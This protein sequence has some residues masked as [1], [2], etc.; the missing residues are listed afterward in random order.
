MSFGEIVLGLLP[1]CIFTVSN[2]LVLATSL[3]ESFAHM[4]LE[5]HLWMF[6]SIGFLEKNPWLSLPFTCPSHECSIHCQ[7]EKINRKP[8]NLKKTVPPQCK[9]LWLDQF[10]WTTTS[11]PLGPAWKQKVLL[12]LTSVNSCS[13]G[14]GLK[15]PEFKC[16]PNYELRFQLQ[17]QHLGQMQHL[18]KQFLFPFLFQAL[19]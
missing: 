13:F 14:L 1:A 5:V 12:E 17:K 18:T 9:P 15:R 2:N 3:E 16:P 4:Y 10:Y 6:N 11:P 19:L 8:V 7:P